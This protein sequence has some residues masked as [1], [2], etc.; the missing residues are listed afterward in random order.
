MDQNCILV[1][2]SLFNWDL[3]PVTFELTSIDL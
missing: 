3:T 2:Y 1:S